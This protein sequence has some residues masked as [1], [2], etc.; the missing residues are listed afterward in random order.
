[1]EFE[2]TWPSVDRTMDALKHSQFSIL[3]I[4]NR[5]KDRYP[6]KELSKT[7][8]KTQDGNIELLSENGDPIT[9]GDG[10]FVSQVVN[11]ANLCSELDDLLEE[12]KRGN[13]DDL[14]TQIK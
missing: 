2:E 13:F 6:E 5:F 7:R 9:F 4:Y 11:Y 1:M 14:L 10:T 8:V 3:E 12:I